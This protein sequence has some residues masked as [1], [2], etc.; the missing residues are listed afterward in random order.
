MSHPYEGYN[1]D[2]E[3]K[4]E[5]ECSSCG[6]FKFK[7]VVVSSNGEGRVYVEC[8]NCYYRKPLREFLKPDGKFL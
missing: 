3:D 4:F 5:E 7:I 1:P 2:A 6:Y 8:D